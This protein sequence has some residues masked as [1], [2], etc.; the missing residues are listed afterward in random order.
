MSLLACKGGIEMSKKS[1]GEGTYR[2]LKSGSWNVQAMDGYTTEG[3]I[4]YI[5]F[6]APTKGE[7]RQLLQ[8]YFTGKATGSK[9]VEATMPFGDWADTWYKDYESQVAAS[10]YAGYLYTLNILKNYFKDVPL[11]KVLPINI[12]RFFDCLVEKDY[13]HSSISKCR[14]MLIQIFDAAEA[15]MLIGFNPARKAKAVK[16]GDEERKK[17]AFTD[18]EVDRI[19]NHHKDDLMGNSIC[20]LVGTGARVQELL[21]LRPESIAEDGSAVSI[22]HAVKMVNGIPIL[23]STKNK[24]SKRVVPVPEDYRQYALYLRNH[25]GKIFIWCSNRADFLYSVGTFRK[26]FYRALREIGGVRLLSPHCCRHTYVTRLDARDVPLDR[27]ARL[28]GHSN[29]STTM[30]YDHTRLET[31]AETVKVLNNNQY[32]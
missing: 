14:A 23:G 24:G 4:N 30:I 27:I 8:N 18:E 21:A 32:L 10:T 11:D 16:S 17:D 25:G 29:V 3:K 13:S 9:S 22:E 31:L 19:L 12:N 28:V 7:A 2:K 6:T 5:S 15:N 26:Q 20:F 1:N